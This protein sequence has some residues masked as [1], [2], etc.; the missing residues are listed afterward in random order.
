[1]VA[2]KVVTVMGS[3]A[4]VFETRRS[5]GVSRRETRRLPS[6]LI[7]KFS[8]QEG[9]A[10]VVRTLTGRG[11]LGGWATIG[12]HVLNEERRVRAER[13]VLMNDVFI[14]AWYKLHGTV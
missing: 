6:D 14:L 11:S 5:S 8:A 13:A 10:K 2:L 3:N 9:K 1:M 7:A 4:F 12:E